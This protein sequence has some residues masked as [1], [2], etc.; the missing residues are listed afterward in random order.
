MAVH[1]ATKH[2]DVISVHEF[3]KHLSN[4]SHKRGILYHGKHLKKS[5]K[6]CSNRKYHVQHNK[7]INH[8]GV[9]MYC[10]TKSFP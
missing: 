7:Y 1:I 4:A 9:K 3:Q 8:Q 10:A 5:R 6:R 2:S